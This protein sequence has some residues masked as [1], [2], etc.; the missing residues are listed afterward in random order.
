MDTEDEKP[1]LRTVEVIG[2]DR[3]RLQ[4]LRDAMAADGIDVEPVEKKLRAL[5]REAEGPP[6]KLPHNQFEECRKASA[7]ADAFVKALEEKL[8]SISQR[9]AELRS[10]E[11]AAE[12]ALAKAREQQSEA[13]KALDA[14][15]AALRPATAPEHEA[16]VAPPWGLSTWM[17]SRAS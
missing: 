17:H 9:L 13:V 14:A 7:K 8:T 2:A 12:R 5:D 1:G 11:A 6:K 3:D 10:D 15:A 4:R 16:A